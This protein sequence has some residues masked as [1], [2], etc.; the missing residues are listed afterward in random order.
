MV[1]IASHT[2]GILENDRLQNQ[3]Q[4]SIHD[5][6]QINAIIG[7]VLGLNTASDVASVAAT[8]MA[9]RFGYELVMVMLLDEALDEFVA[10]G[11]GGEGAL[12][13]PTGL[14]Y[15]SHLGIP[16]EVMRSG[17]SVFLPDVEV[18]SSYIKIPDWEPGSQM[19]VPLRDGED[20]FGLISVEYQEKNAVAKS[21]LAILESLA[22]ALSNVLVDTRRYE[23]LQIT[24]SQLEVVRETALDISADLDLDVLMKRVV[25]RVRGLLDARGAELG[26]VDEDEQVVR[27]LVSENPWKD[28]SGYTFPLMQGVAGRIAGI[29]EPVVVPDF[30]Q[31]SGGPEEGRPSSFTTVAGVPLKLGGEVIGTLVVQDDRAGRSFTQDDMKVLELLSPQL[32]IFIRNARLYQELEE[33]IEAQHLAESRLIQSAKLAAVGEMAAGVAHELNNPLTTVT[34]F[35]ELIL[36]TMSKDS[37]E[38]EDMTLILQEAH[39]VR[40]VVRQLLDFTR[41]SEILRVH[42]DINEV[43]SAVLGLVSHQAQTSKVEVRI[44]FWDGLPMVRVDRNQMQQVF[45]NLII[46]AIQAMPDGG[47]LIIQ[48]EVEKQD[49]KEWIVVKIMD[50]GQGIKKEFLDQ[51]FEPFFTTKPS[52]EGTGL[53]LS[54]S[55]GIVSDHGGVIEVEGE[56]G[57]GSTF[58]VRLPVETPVKFESEQVNV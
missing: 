46:N 34:G 43:L 51:I 54:V 3:T 21:D 30:G 11:L 35:A 4:T 31:W 50:S 15:A 28:F 40:S 17:D 26:L 42:L 16:G 39:R 5:L 1:V 48:T 58:V 49:D 47:R 14:R 12:D 52:G 53:G 36:E 56:E 55:F 22:G 38:Y 6:R 20:I 41:Q 10:E 9:E 2:A 13:F 37:T 8:V 45:L 29:G 25:N 32:T 23:E 33:R 27:I 7:Q 24:A 18:S 57:K 44:A 19:C